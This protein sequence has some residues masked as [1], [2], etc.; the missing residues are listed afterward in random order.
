MLLPY[1]GIYQSRNRRYRFCSVGYR[2][3]SAISVVIAL[4]QQQKILSVE[5]SNT[6][7]LKRMGEAAI[8]EPS[9][10]EKGELPEEEE[11]KE[12]PKPS[13][14]Q[15]LEMTTTAEPAADDKKVSDSESPAVE[16]KVEEKKEEDTPVDVKSPPSVSRVASKETSSQTVDPRKAVCKEKTT[17]KKK[18]DHKHNA[19]LP[20]RTSDIKQEV[21]I[22]M[23]EG[24]ASIP[25]TTV[26][27]LFDTTVLR[28]PDEPALYQKVLD[29]VVCILQM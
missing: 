12:E 14:K 3:E 20:W 27:E 25:P 6:L 16:D 13:L 18:F 19:T 4:C 26:M 1:V 17:T 23:G 10:V 9:K 8:E 28:F 15:E 5:I 24:K 7:L 22:R 29:S 2:Y 21:R 11:K